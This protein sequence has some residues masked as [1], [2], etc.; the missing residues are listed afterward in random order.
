[1]I[2]SIGYKTEAFN[3]YCASSGNIDNRMKEACFDIQILLV[4]FFTDAINTIRGEFET[5]RD[6][7][8]VGKHG[9]CSS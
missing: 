8:C 3:G 4:E 7:E 5:L 6:G 9:F 1:M 2:K